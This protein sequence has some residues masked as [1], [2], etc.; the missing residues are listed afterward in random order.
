MSVAATK[1]AA[2][3]QRDRLAPEAPKS[4][5]ARSN[6]IANGSL[7]EM[8]AIHKE[9]GSAYSSRVAATAIAG[10]TIHRSKMKKRRPPNANTSELAA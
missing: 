3:R 4:G 5:T 9:L 10:G 2:I 7:R 1:M 6:V 8:P